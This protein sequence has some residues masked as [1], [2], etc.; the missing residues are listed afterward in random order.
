MALT[1]NIGKEGAGVGHWAGNYKF[2]VFN[3]LPA[4]NTEDPFNMNLDPQADGQDIQVHKYYKPENVA[5]NYGRP[6]GGRPDVHQHA[7]HAHQGAVDANVN[8][9]NNASGPTTWPAT[10]TKTEMI[11]VN[12][13]EWTGSCEF[14][15][16]VLPVQCWVE[17]QVPEMTASCSNP[18]L[19]A[20]GDGRGIKP[21]FDNRSD[22]EIMAL[23][24]EQLSKITGDQRYRDSSSSSWRA[25]RRRTS[26]ASWTPARRR[27]ATR[28]KS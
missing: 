5:W 10:W 19:Q 6:H 7:L 14:A 12:E 1:G 21:L 23:V 9:L 16:V 28:S 26:S 18:F 15:D 11:V 27:G 2:P 4:F 13:M 22:A 24:A 17:L 3:G 20:W 8:L 25:T